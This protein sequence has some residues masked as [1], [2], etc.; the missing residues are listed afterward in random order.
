MKRLGNCANGLAYTWVIDVRRAGKPR[1]D[2][3]LADAC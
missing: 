3:D 1:L 2:R